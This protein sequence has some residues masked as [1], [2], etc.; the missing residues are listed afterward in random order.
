MLNLF[1]S[2]VTSESCK[3][4]KLKLQYNLSY[5]EIVYYTLYIFGVNNDG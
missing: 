3:L 4:E 5:P 2:Y 1:I